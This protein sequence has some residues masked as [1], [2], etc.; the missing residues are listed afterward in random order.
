M[1]DALQ[2]LQIVVDRLSD[3]LDEIGAKLDMI[4]E[5]VA[6]IDYRSLSP[7]E[8]AERAFDRAKELTVGYLRSL[9]QGEL[10]EL[11]VL[12]YDPPN[13]EPFVEVIEYRHDEVTPGDPTE[14]GFLVKGTARVMR[15][16][17][18]WGFEAQGEMLGTRYTEW[19]P[20]SFYATDEECSTLNCCGNIRRRL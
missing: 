1:P 17:K 5:K 4:S 8:K 14:F 10:L 7:N 11:I 15:D 16:P 9:Q 18:E 13:E 6:D 12:S 3:K 2:N 19:T 20:Y